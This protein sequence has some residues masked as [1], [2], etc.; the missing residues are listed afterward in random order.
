[1]QISNGILH[2]ETSSTGARIHTLQKGSK[3]F[4]YP[5]QYVDK[6][7]GVVMR[8]GMH[9]CSPI[10]GSPDGKGVFSQEPQH[11]AL[12][13]LCWE[14]AE[15]IKTHSTL[16]LSY[17]I[18][19]RVSGI[20]L[21]YSVRYFMEKNKLTTDTRIVNVVGGTVDVELGWHPYFNAPQGGLINFKGNGIDTISI[22]GDFKPTIVP[23]CESIIIEL[24]SIGKVKMLLEKGFDDGYI[25]IWTDWRDKYICV[26][27]LISYKKYSPGIA[28][29]MH[30]SISAQFSMIFD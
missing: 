4:L 19:H 22:A 30:D 17:P 24:P 1:M 26:E 11:G 20:Q 16:G 29:D 10:F 13:N 2:A 3:H 9:I 12:R 21:L 25:C 27:P 6:N 8:G 14:S 7:N 5:Q 18:L 15:E 28:L 23:A